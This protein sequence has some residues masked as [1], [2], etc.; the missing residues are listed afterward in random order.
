[1]S[2]IVNPHLCKYSPILPFHLFAGGS[3]LIPDD[4]DTAKT[5]SQESRIA[6]RQSLSTAAAISSKNRK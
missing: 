3:N 5:R 2:L 1:M 4:S 6:D